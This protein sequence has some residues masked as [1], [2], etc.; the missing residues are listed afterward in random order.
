MK[1]NHPGWQS[2]WEVALGFDERERPA[3]HVS[4]LHMRL[5]DVQGLAGNAAELGLSLAAIPGR[6]P[7]PLPLARTMR[8]R[9]S[10]AR[11][12]MGLS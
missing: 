3:V 2:R 7:W 8:R 1:S 11:C 10:F 12:G 4:G 9:W 5:E 6:Y